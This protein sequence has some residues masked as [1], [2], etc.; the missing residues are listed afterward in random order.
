MNKHQPTP[1]QIRLRLLTAALAIAA[2]VTA[3]LI[4]VLELKGI[5]A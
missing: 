4:A 2:G 1:T 5:L 3:I